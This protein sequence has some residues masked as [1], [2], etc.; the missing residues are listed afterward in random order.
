M[1]MQNLMAQAQKMQRE[2]TTAKN[3]IDSKIFNS[4][5]EFVSVQFS[6]D[7]K[8][9]TIKIKKKD[10][11]ESDIEVLEDMIGIAIEDCYRQIDKETEQKL[12]KYGNS[13]NGLL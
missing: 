1:N 4:E 12:G 9:K 7:K 2:I 3:E 5:N 8:L 13:L 10:L 11:D 6:G